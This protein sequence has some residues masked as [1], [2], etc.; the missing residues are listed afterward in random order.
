MGSFGKTGAFMREYRVI[1]LHT[2]G[3]SYDIFQ[4]MNSIAT[5]KAQHTE[6]RP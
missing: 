6:V 3:N 2:F 1:L 5:S 4:G